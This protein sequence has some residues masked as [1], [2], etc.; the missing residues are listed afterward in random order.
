MKTT[1]NLFAERLPKGK[2][3]VRI[4]VAT[5]LILCVPLVAMQFTEQV[6][7]NVFDFVVMGL[8]LFGVGLAY[9]MLAMHLQSARQRLIAGAVLLAVLL[10]VWAELAVG[11][12]GT[13][14]AGS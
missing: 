4:A 8:L 3:I 2:N 14:F 12:F 5:L 7:W 1:E 9:E 6:D 10:A 11:V 13:P